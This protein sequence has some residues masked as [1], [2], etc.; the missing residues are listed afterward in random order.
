MPPTARRMTLDAA[1]HLAER[2]ASDAARIAG[3][4][5]LR[6]LPVTAIFRR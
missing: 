3:G 5:T 1:R 2:G 4:G 6:L